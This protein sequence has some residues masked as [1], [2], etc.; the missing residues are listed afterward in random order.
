MQDGWM[1]RP[2]VYRKVV[3]SALTLVVTLA[4]FFTGLGQYQGEWQV[5]R[6]VYLSTAAV[7]FILGLIPW[8]WIERE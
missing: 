6:A 1:D 5:A 2:E 8:V 3:F 7:V 4:L